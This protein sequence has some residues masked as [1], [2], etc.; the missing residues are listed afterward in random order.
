MTRDSLTPDAG[1]LELRQQMLRRLSVQHAVSGVLATAE[2]FET[3]A[4]DLLK[5][6]GEALDWQFGAAWT[7]DPAQNV[8]RCSHYWHPAELSF[9]KFLA[10]TNALVLHIGEGL[11]GEVWSRGAPVFTANL[12]QEAAFPRSQVAGAEGLR[13]A[14]AFPIRG[15]RFV[16]VIE[17]FS[18]QLK[19]SDEELFRTVATLGRQIGQFIDRKRAESD[20][21]Q[22]EARKASVFHASLDAIVSIDRQSRIIDW[23][24]AAEKMFG[25]RKEEVL[26]KDMADLIIPAL[27]ARHRHGLC[28]YLSTGEG[29]VLDRRIEVTALRADGS[30]FPVELA[31]SSIRLDHAVMFTGFLRDISERKQ[32]EESLRR[33][34]RLATYTAEVGLAL[35]AVD[36][37]RSMLQRCAELTVEHLDAAFARVWTLN[38]ADNVLELQASAGLYTHLDG[39][40]SR[41][42]VGRFKIG[43]IAKERLPHMTN[44]VLDDPRVSDKEW[45]VREGMV[46]FAGYPLIVED[47]L[48]GV[49]AIF[50][51]QKQTGETL[52]A[53]GSVA[54]GI[55]LGIRRKRVEEALRTAVE[56][57]G[58]ANLAKSQFLANMSH[59]LR[60]PLNAV[61]LYSELL[62]EEAEDRGAKEFLPDLEKIRAA[63]Q[64]LLALINNILDLSKIEAGKMELYLELFDVS[65]I[66]EEVVS[67]TRPLIEKNLNTF[68]V[69]C[70]SQLGTMYADTTKVRQLL[71][72]LLGNAAK[73]TENG[74]VRL[75]VTRTDVDGAGWLTFE[76]S[77][78]G[79]GM[80]P[81]QLDKLFQAF[82]QADSS[83]TRR[84]GG[85]GLG[86]AISK[87]L[88]GI[89]GG[90]ISVQSEVG[91]G[92]AFSVS[93]PA[94]VP[95]AI[96]KEPPAPEQKK[97][98]SD[99][100][101]RLAGRP[102]VLVIDDDPLV[103]ETMVR[104]LT[105]ERYQVH[106]AQDGEEALR[107]AREV[108]PDVVTLDVIMPRMDGWAVLKAFKADPELAGIPIVMLTIMDE[109]NL[110]YL[111]GA[112]EYMTKPL[113]RGRMA[114]LLK[115]LC[116]G[117]STGRILIIDD[118]EPIRKGMRQLLEQNGW[119]VS[120]A[121]DGLAALASVEAARPDLILLDLMMPGMDG[122][123][124]T[125]ELRK[126]E[127]WRTIPVVV[128]TAKDLTQED[129]RILN[130]YVQ[131]ILLKDPSTRDELLRDIE[132]LLSSC[133]RNKMSAARWEDSNAQN[134]AD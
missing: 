8:L 14:L 19:P 35:T 45:A 123:Q 50:A 31:I 116:P 17:F 100:V 18:D 72:N 94:L 110:G 68:S 120:E 49:V 3:C 20:L 113:D 82:S 28:H 129:R 64:H 74:E 4:P 46:A 79:I 33:R 125:A 101:P 67:L 22:S 70:G 117:R 93:I 12:V 102:T 51:R 84:Y 44:S 6:M 106:T 40:H 108:K 21:R 119:G 105:K 16:G 131:K 87:R 96:P 81:E 91:S 11:P 39:P 15:G 1:P 63:G 29:S 88:A 24:E 92:T 42:P 112:A 34:T 57:A 58:E 134:P 2:N 97:E 61:I 95:Q 130:G 127:A 132:D 43:L 76:V 75:S 9:P 104:L 38:E 37:L 71:V 124:F 26:G 7:L 54:H 56:A 115:R 59:E 98:A 53:L 25:R 122:F 10:M 66:V 78:S 52:Q 90:D 133:T 27:G 77:D 13:G 118:E 60:T 83:T 23:N 41:V 103:R 36:D 86:L 85:T 32:A 69:R 89:M 121:T 99:E 55:A 114:E 65:P 107:L 80:T 73:F 30:E 126:T 109:R 5:A 128:M 111:L 62:Q 48:M 47:Q